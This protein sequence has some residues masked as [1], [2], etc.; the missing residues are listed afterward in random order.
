MEIV[1]LVRPEMVWRRCNGIETD[2]HGAGWSRTAKILVLFARL[3]L[4]HSNRI[5]IKV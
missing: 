1:S 3:L 5:L 4:S 2:R